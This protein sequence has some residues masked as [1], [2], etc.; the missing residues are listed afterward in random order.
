MKQVAC[1][2]WRQED[3]EFKANLHKIMSSIPCLKKQNNKNEYKM[4]NFKVSII[5][6]T[7]LF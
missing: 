2:R 4:A 1:G 3:Q 7:Q 5:I 6:L